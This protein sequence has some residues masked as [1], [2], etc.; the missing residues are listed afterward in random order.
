MHK[1]NEHTLNH[2]S[3][4]QDLR[5]L[6][7]IN[8]VHKT[9]VKGE[10]NGTNGTALVKHM[11]TTPLFLQWERVKTEQLG[12]SMSIPSRLRKR[13]LQKTQFRVFLWGIGLPSFGN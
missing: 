5:K 6:W 11:Q 7:T 10:I 8:W 1:I 3:P 9:N 12:Q 2:I 4:S 13:G